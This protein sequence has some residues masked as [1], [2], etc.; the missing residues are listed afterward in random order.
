MA[1]HKD[2]K[3]YACLHCDKT[4]KQHS[5]LQNHQIIHKKPGEVNH[6]IFKFDLF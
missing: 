1:I 4:F 2:D 6:H 3:P 5:Q